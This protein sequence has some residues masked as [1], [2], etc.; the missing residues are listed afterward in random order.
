MGLNF[1]Q[2]P[3]SLSLDNQKV[4]PTAQGNILAII[5]HSCCQDSIFDFIFSNKKIDA[6]HFGSIDLTV[7]HL[8]VIKL[9]VV[10]VGAS[11]RS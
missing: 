11:E 8:S 5:G 4:I 10:E 1:L 9:G 6:V 7:H 3:A 2:F